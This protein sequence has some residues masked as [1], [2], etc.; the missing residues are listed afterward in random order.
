[1]IDF[2]GGMVV[3][4]IFFGTIFYLG[5][6]AFPWVPILCA[7]VGLVLIAV[8]LASRDIA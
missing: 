4:S 8:G 7:F 3:G 5:T 6:S 2:G 1:M